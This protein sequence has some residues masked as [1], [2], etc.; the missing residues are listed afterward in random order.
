VHRLRV[1][2]TVLAEKK[3]VRECCA[4]EEERESAHE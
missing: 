2:V 1:R 4:E 3:C